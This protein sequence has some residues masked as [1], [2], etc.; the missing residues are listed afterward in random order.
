MS[1]TVFLNGRLH[2]LTC[3]P[4]PI[5]RLPRLVKL[6]GNLEVF[7]RL[8][9]VHHRKPVRVEAQLVKYLQSCQEQG[10]LE[11]PIASTCVLF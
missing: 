7:I 8:L 11:S 4:W 1:S 5:K 3:L 2:S 9:Q 10:N 6:A